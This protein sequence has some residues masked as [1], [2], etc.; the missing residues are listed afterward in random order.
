MTR[1]ESL[2]RM[3]TW[4]RDPARS[5]VPEAWR[6]QWTAFWSSLA[7]RERRLVATA[8]TVVLVAIAYLVL[9]E[10]AARARTQ[11]AKELPVLREQAAEMSSLAR[12]AQS[13]ANAVPAPVTGAA[14]RTALEDTLTRHGL[15]PTQLTVHD[16][17]VQLQLDGV[18]FG[19]WSDWLTSVRDAYR[20]QV[21]E[22]QIRYVGATALVN[23]RAVLQAPSQALSSS[24]R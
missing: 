15:K 19:A 16:G 20:L 18:T 1:V 8:L 2:S 14:Q 21:K 24:G 22:A 4:L 17:T 23:V 11:L 3:R 6:T 12:E 10:P 13:L 7:P 9:W 5:L